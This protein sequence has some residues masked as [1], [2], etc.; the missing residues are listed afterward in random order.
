ME[1]KRGNKQMPIWQMAMKLK[2]KMKKLHT[3]EA[4]MHRIEMQLSSQR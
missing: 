1:L 4:L 2:Y 3:N